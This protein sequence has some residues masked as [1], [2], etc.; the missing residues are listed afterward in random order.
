[1]TDRP[2]RRTYKS[3]Y[4]PED[5]ER[6]RFEK[7]PERSTSEASHCQE[8]WVAMPGTLTVEICGRAY[9]SDEDIRRVEE[10]DGPV[11]LGQPVL[12]VCGRVINT[13]PAEGGYMRKTKDITAEELAS[14]GL[15]INKETEK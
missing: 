11:V 5:F 9:M 4:K 6:L 7:L 12:R 3:V 13:I 8:G 14:F 1:M 15:D 10:Y 2:K